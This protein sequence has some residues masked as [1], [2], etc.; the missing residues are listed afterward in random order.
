[1]LLI[2]LSENPRKRTIGQFLFSKLVARPTQQNH[3]KT[4]GN[5]PKKN[6]ETNKIGIIFV[7]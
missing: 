7:I 3:T 6:R 4:V 5:K 1:L 2:F